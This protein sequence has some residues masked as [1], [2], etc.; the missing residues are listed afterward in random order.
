LIGKT[1]NGSS[2]VKH[3]SSMDFNQPGPRWRRISMAAAIIS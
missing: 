1:K 2:W 3:S